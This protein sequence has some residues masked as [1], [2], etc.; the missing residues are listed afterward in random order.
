MQDPLVRVL[1]QV[2]TAHQLSQASIE[3]CMNL[4]QG[5]YR[6]IARGRRPLP[7]YRHGLTSWVRDFEDCVDATVEE[8]QAIL[9]HL[10]EPILEHFA[11]LL[12]DIN[13]HN[14]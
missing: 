6:H 1:E 11:I 13:R 8:R 3:D 10:S 12:D 9:R 4:P 5:A 14:G 2:R 7:D